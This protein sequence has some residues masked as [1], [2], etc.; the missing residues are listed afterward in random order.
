MITVYYLSFLATLE[1]QQYDMILDFPNEVPAT[2]EMQNIIGFWI[3]Q[4]RFTFSI[5]PS[6]DPLTEGALRFMG[7]IF[8]FK[9]KLLEHLPTVSKE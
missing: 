3:F 7:K 9:L 6:G 1:T 4:M 5:F 8:L 2:L